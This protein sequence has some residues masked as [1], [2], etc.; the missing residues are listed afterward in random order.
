[1]SCSFFSKNGYSIR[2]TGP[3]LNCGDIVALRCYDLF[4]RDVSEEE[5]FRDIQVRH[6]NRPVVL[7]AAYK[8]QDAQGL[9]TMTG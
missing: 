6:E 7:D 8:D 5:V 3:L 2:K 9:L 4:R 1:M